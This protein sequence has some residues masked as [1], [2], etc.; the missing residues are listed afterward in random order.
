MVSVAFSVQRF[1]GHDGEQSALV[2]NPTEHLRV[3]G[4]RLP[5]LRAGSGLGPIESAVLEEA[6]R[7]SDIARVCIYRGRD[8][9]GRGS[10]GF[11]ES[12]TA[13]ERNELARLMLRDQLMVYRELLRLG[14]GLFIHTE[15]GNLEVSAYRSAAAHHIEANALVLADASASPEERARA[16]AD[17]WILRNV[18]FFFGNPMRS[19]LERVLPDKIALLDRR[20]QRVREKAVALP[21][22]SPHAVVASPPSDPPFERWRSARSGR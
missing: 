21:P 7:L 10:W 12:T 13:A 22:E 8:D 2:V 9:E 19:I 18:T 6:R 11:C 5:R 14:I 3:D 17:Q 20:M 4:G 15:F 16:D 1:R